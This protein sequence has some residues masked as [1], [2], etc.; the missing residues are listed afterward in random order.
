MRELVDT[1]SGANTGWVEDLYE[2]LR[3]S[4]LARFKRAIDKSDGLA[5]T[6]RI[7]NEKKD[8]TANKCTNSYFW[9]QGTGSGSWYLQNGVKAGMSVVE[10]V[11][12]LIKKGDSDGKRA[13]M[14]KHIEQYVAARAA[15]ADKNGW[16][17]LGVFRHTDADAASAGPSAAAGPLLPTRQVTKYA[18]DDLVMKVIDV[19]GAKPTPA[20]PELAIPLAELGGLMGLESVKEQAAKLVKLAT[21][22]YERELRGESPTSSRSTASS[23]AT[24]APARRPSPRSTAAY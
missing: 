24:P 8:A 12:A 23:S 2:A 7:Y 9:L 6:E 20:A 14:L 13:Q 18:A 22:N 10:M 4:D 16:K 5:A 21:E 19:V 1:G 17:T 15:A 11:K 3:H